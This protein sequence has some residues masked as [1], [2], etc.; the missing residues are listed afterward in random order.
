[1]RPDGTQNNPRG[2]GVSIIPADS[3]EQP[4]VNDDGIISFSPIFIESLQAP[5]YKY[6]PL[7]GQLIFYKTAD[8]RYW[9]IPV[10]LL[11]TRNSPNH[12]TK[13]VK[14]VFPS[15]NE[16]NKIWLKNSPRFVN[17]NHIM[18]FRNYFGLLNC[19]ICL[20]NHKKSKACQN[21]W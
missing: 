5:R 20:K 19:D 1:M 13:L 6:C 18:T 16:L 2:R 11:Q 7:Y 12:S 8:Q 10:T 15:L 14:L 17:I 9:N 21:V 4:K 3:N